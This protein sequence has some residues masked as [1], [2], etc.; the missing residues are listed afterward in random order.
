MIGVPDPAAGQVPKAFIVLKDD[1]GVTEDEI[2]EFVEENVA[3]YK[4]LRGGVEFIEAIPKSVNGKVLRQ[5]LKDRSKQQN[6]MPKMMK[7]KE[8]RNSIRHGYI[9][10]KNI[11]NNVV[12]K[13][14]N[15]MT[16]NTCIII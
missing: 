10:T 7:T 16:S 9:R 11:H 2:M 3:T 8:R 4:K 13:R 12:Y 5:V 14:N 1:V 15:T 6:L